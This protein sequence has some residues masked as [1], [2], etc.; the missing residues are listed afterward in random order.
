[1]VKSNWTCF[2]SHRVASYELATRDFCSGAP[3][4]GFP[5]IAPVISACGENARPTGSEIPRIIASTP[6]DVTVKIGDA[7][8][9]KRYFRSSS[10]IIVASPSC[11]AR[12]QRNIP[13]ARKRTD[14]RDGPS[15][16]PCKLASRN[17]YLCSPHVAESRGHD[18]INF[19][20]W[21]IEQF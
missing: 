18:E 12:K 3:C 16:V 7:S 1:M 8:R 14:V 13:W 11:A 5:I 17:D 4:T 9:E 19:G 2:C 6:S 15:I 10:Q 20:T 21:P